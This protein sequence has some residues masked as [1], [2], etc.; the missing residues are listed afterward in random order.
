MRMPPSFEELAKLADDELDVCL[1]AALIAR[2]VYANLD[3]DALLAQLA[4]LAAPLASAGLDRMPALEQAARLA[5]YLYEERGFCGNEKNYY[6]PKN[7]LLPDVL[8][9]HTGIPITLA[10]VYCEVARRAGVRALGV[11]F[12]GH[13]LVRVERNRSA[14]E[15]P[16]ATE[17]S[18][19]VLDARL[20]TEGSAGVLGAHGPIVVDPFFGGK[21][22]EEEGVLRIL[23]RAAGPSA[24]LRPEYLAPAS[25]RAIL[26]RMLVN[27][28]SVHLARG[29][30]ARAHLALDRIVS[31]MPESPDAL[32]ERGL[33]AAKLGATE[34]ARADLSRALELGPNDEENRAIR[35]E[36][37][38]LGNARRSLN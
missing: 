7:S 30:H 4:E 37:A 22:L 18:A 23:R 27:L 10:I 5:A 32:R 3:V 31:L 9:R 19:G 36:L 33:I 29:D 16:G 24:K 17:G 13:F 26:V 12:P 1:G 20:P 21:V 14:G 8:E 28:K 34:S 35:A 25:P 38:K 11:S 15:P 2:D 6:D